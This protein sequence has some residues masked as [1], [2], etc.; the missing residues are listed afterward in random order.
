MDDSSLL[1]A[2]ANLTA[3]LDADL[4][5]FDTGDTWQRY[6]RLPDNAL[7]APDDRQQVVL[8]MGSLVETLKRFDR[9][10]ANPKYVQ[11]S[12]LPSFAA[13]H[14]AI[15]ETV[16]RYGTGGIDRSGDA[17]STS[18]AVPAKPQ[19][20]SPLAIPDGPVSIRQADVGQN[21]REAAR[22]GR[23]RRAD[24]PHPRR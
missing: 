6:L 23:A 9:T 14:A 11:I 13:A 5:R 8:G 18:A 17:H 2:V 21:L 24:A 7:P 10:V 15:E 20:D 19:P 12:G 4:E 16:R 1:N 3:Q 22:D